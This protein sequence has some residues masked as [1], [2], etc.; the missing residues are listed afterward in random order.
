MSGG[1]YD[2]GAEGARMSLEGAMSYGDYLDLGRVLTA[3]HCR[4]TSH[5]EMLF[6]TPASDQRIVDAAGDP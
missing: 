2:P 4:T 6:I 1:A 3:Q 5:D